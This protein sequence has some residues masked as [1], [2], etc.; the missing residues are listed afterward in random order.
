[1]LSYQIGSIQICK[2]I[3]SKRFSYEAFVKAEG[4]KDLRI[5]TVEEQVTMPG[6]HGSRRDTH[7]IHVT[8]LLIFNTRIIGNR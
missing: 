8:T 3:P 7:S 4:Q 6:E 1:M 2:H 5:V